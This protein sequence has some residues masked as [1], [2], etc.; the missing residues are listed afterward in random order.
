MPPRPEYR[1]VKVRVAGYE[2]LDRLVAALT[3]HGWSAV[4]VVRDE[5]VSSL[6]VLELALELLEKRLKAKR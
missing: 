5:R 1:S 3:Q 2:R 6:N 4:D